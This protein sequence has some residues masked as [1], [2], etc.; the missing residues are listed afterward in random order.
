MRGEDIERAAEVLRLFLSGDED[1]AVEAMRA[2]PSPLLSQLQD[3]GTFLE[4]AAIGV[5]MDRPSDSP[6]HR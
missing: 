6:L 5:L 1:G 2:L 4:D 3:A